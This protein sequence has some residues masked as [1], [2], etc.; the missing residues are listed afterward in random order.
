LTPME[1]LNRLLENDQL[2]AAF[3]LVPFL[4]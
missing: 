3:E 4:F 2:K 1:K